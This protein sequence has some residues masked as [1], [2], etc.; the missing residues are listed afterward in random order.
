MGVIFATLNA[1]ILLAKHE[2]LR[3]PL[4]LERR[5]HILS[6][7]VAGVI[8]YAIATALAAVSSYAT[9]AI[10]ASLALF[11]ALPIGSG[12]NE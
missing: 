12:G 3:N 1:H 5:R 8:P 9:L 10:C 6:R 4:P 2:R 7:S 11:Y